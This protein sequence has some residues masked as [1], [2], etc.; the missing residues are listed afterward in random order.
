MN[1]PSANNIEPTPKPRWDLHRQ[2]TGPGGF[3]F[4]FSL[5]NAAKPSFRSLDSPDG[6]R[7][8]FNA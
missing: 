1:T 7:L 6:G 2:P 8:K 4:V 5:E 3:H